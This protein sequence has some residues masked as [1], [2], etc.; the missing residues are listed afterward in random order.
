MAK[1]G[2]YGGFPG[3]MNMNNLMAQAQRMQQ[4][5]QKTQEEV[6]GREVETVAGGGA[7]RVVATGGRIIKSIEIAPELVDRDDIEMLQDTVIAAVNDAL[8][9]AKD[10]HDAEMAKL[11]GGANLGGMF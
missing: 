9:K 2:G 8:L 4:Q 6:E 5:M 1:K 10:M 7:V 3:G 11:T